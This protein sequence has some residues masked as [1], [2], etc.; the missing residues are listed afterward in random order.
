MEKR[1][2]VVVVRVIL[3]LLIWFGFK[4]HPTVLADEQ[5]VSFT[6]ND[7]SKDKQIANAKAGT[8]NIY[9]QQDLENYLAKTGCD[10]TGDAIWFY[11]TE[12]IIFPKGTYYVDN[13][14]LDF[15]LPSANGSIDFNG[16]T[17]LIGDGAATMRG[18]GEQF[19]RTFSNLT[20][21]GTTGY[22]EEYIFGQ[23]NKNPYT[24]TTKTGAWDAYLYHVSNMNFSHLTLN[25]AQNM[26]GHLFDV[27]GS[28]HIV[29]DDIR[30]H[31]SA[32]STD[33][34][35]ESL[36]RLYQRRSH[37]IFSEAIQFDSA[38]FGSL[39]IINGSYDSFFDGSQSWGKI[40]NGESYDGRASTDVTISHSEFTS[41]Q[42]PT[43]LSLIR[44]TDQS[45]S[46]YGSG[47]GS[48]TVG[49]T[50]Y[51]G[52]VIDDVLMEGTVYV[53]ATPNTDLAP[54]KFLNSDYYQAHVDRDK[55]IKKVEYISQDIVRQ[56]TDIQ[57]TNVRYINTNTS[58]YL[59][60]S[61]VDIPNSVWRAYY[62]DDQNP[63]NNKVISVENCD[64]NGNILSIVEGYSELAP[65]LRHNDI[66]Y[67]LVETQFDST[68]GQLKRIYQVTEEETMKM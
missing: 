35:Q 50:G 53:A 39:G 36:Q 14:Y 66:T 3:G 64:M 6:W 24:E 21:Y 12:D 60:P 49:K 59:N 25:N 28:D 68:S 8:V 22:D 46:K 1:T 16:S 32:L 27:I 56:T 13:G 9:T 17:L 29:F 57:V 7:F 41:Y 33:F 52:I 19:H 58:G 18:N 67:T 2:Y 15:Y 65:L 63:D 62:D 11:N 44:R 38:I 34:S 43:G 45:V 31:G 23:E 51:S 10:L 55:T 30:A 20:I 26:D 47:L 4:S 5:A 40:W 48:H 37:T 54:I 42:G 61:G